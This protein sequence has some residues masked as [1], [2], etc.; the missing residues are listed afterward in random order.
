MGGASK[1][2]QGIRI[3]RSN[4]P[5]L[6]S[7]ATVF[8]NSQGIIARE[9]RCAREY[10]QENLSGITMVAIPS[11]Q[12]WMGSE[13]ESK[14]S[15]QP[16]H[17]VNISAF[18]MSQTPVTQAQWRAVAR[19]PQEAIELE[20]NPSRFEEDDLPVVR[21]TWREAIEFCARLSR[22]T[23][24]NYRLPSEAEWEYACKALPL[25]PKDGVYPP[26]HFGET[27]TKD[28]ANFDSD[29]TTAVKSFYP[30]AFGLY[31]M[32]GNVWEWCLDPWHD[33]YVGAPTDGRVWDDKYNRN[34]YQN[35]L[36]GIHILIKDNSCHVLRGGSWIVNPRYCRSA[37]R[38]D[39][40]YRFWRVLN[41]VGFRLVCPP[42][43]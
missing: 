22:Y 30:N 13:D 24:R 14:S 34:H 32:H 27:L 19:L 35:L 15:E 3:F 41:Y 17:L 31:D 5:H 42:Q 37:Y 11:G 4:I 21:V 9:Q 20:L 8:V 29:T 23:G 36:N 12:F 18:Y 38:Y 2:A 33:N 10:F 40:A 39:F 6:F 26:Y 28:L 16:K 43:D 1:Q 7:F 25:P